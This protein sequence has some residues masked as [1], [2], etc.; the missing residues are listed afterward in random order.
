CRSVAFP[1]RPDL[2]DDEA[3]H[4]CGQQGGKQTSGYGCPQGPACS[5]RDSG[6]YR[7]ADQ[8]R[9]DA[10]E[11]NDYVQHVPTCFVSRA[12]CYLQSKVVGNGRLAPCDRQCARMGRACAEGGS[13]GT[14][15]VSAGT[16]RRARGDACGFIL[17]DTPS[18]IWQK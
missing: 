13:H 5:E 14:G 18:N 17:L 6:P 9:D 12:G 8:V 4:E 10:S 3:P 7:N 15:W 2:P 11:V 16:S 1:C